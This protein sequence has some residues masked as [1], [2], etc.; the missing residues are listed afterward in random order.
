M[1]PSREIE[2]EMGARAASARAALGRFTVMPPCTVMARLAIMKNTSRKK[3][4]AIRRALSLGEPGGDHARVR[5][6]GAAGDLERLVQ[7]AAL[8]QLER[9]LGGAHV[10]LSP[11]E[12]EP[13]DHHGQG[14]HGT[15]HQGNH[16]GPALGEHLDQRAD[17]KHDGPLAAGF[18]T[19]TAGSGGSLP[20][21]ETPVEVAGWGERVT[22]SGSACPPW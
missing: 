11:P 7:L 22:W 15:E 17:V 14:H 2:T 20:G 1:R 4:G 13:L 10:A 16:H 6:A 18:V 19:G 3:T 9:A 8:G 21:R 12:A 5:G